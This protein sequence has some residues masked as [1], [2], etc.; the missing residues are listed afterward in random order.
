MWKIGRRVLIAASGL[1]TRSTLRT[2]PCGY[3][4]HSDK[5]VYPLLQTAP[6]WSLKACLSACTYASVDRRRKQPSAGPNSTAVAGNASR[7]ATGGQQTST[8]HFNPPEL[9][10]STPRN[11]HSVVST[12]QLGLERPPD[13][14]PP[15]RLSPTTDRRGSFGE[16]QSDGHGQT[17]PGPTADDNV[18]LALLAKAMANEQFSPDSSSARAEAGGDESVSGRDHL[19]T[20][21]QELPE[22]VSLDS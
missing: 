18:T 12:P 5:S 20:L 11:E 4:S 9:V 1:T 13:T 16:V 21:S 8:E 10:I 7:P 15:A 6:S 17:S 14:P 2:K 22:G 3:C 19:R